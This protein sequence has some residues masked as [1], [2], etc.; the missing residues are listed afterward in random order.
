MN[1]FNVRYNSDKTG[2]AW[3]TQV[4][5]NDYREA[6]RIG[7]AEF[8]LLAL[9]DG[10][11]LEAGWQYTLAADEYGSIALIVEG[12]TAEDCENILFDAE[13]YDSRI[14]IR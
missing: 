1:N 10:Q 13:V 7:A 6:E 14:E 3:F 5:A 12:P 2:E 8:L 9:K 4:Q 11:K